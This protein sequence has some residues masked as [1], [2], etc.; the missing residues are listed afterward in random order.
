MD[1]KLYEDYLE[2]KKKLTEF[3]NKA[4]KKLQNLEVY[5]QD[6]E[7]IKKQFIEQLAYRQCFIRVEFPEACEKFVEEIERKLRKFIYFHD[8]EEV[9]GSLIRHY[10][11][12]LLED[13]GHYYDYLT[14]A[15][16]PLDFI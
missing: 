15:C 13:M 6:E 3:Y 8:G 11:L 12:K 9:D 1:K 2:N 16:N 4:I 10:R 5:N 14:C 7:Y